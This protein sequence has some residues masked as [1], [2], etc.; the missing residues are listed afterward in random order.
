MENSG[1]NVELITSYYNK[2]KGKNRVIND[3]CFKR[4]LTDEEIRVL[5]GLEAKKDGIH[6]Q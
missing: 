2:N 6:K 5:F 3:K 4:N 1:N